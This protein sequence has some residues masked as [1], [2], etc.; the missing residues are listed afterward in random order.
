M[1]QLAKKPTK[2]ASNALVQIRWKTVD[3]SKI[4]AWHVTYLH[5]SQKER[6]GRSLFVGGPWADGN[7]TFQSAEFWGPFWK[8]P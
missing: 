4:D 8:M 2:T 5:C 1:L 3:S 6:K 7:A